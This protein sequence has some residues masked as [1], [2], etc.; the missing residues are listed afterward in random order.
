MYLVLFQFNIYFQKVL[1]KHFGTPMH[2]ILLSDKFR[3]SWIRVLN[4]RMKTGGRDMKAKKL[5]VLISWEMS[6]RV[7]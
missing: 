2:E 3:L 5:L 1:R 6:K 4:H 7:I